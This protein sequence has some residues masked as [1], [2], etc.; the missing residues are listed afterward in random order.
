M[1]EITIA[2][3]IT[4]ASGA[5]AGA[6]V[7]AFIAGVGWRKLPFA[8]LLSLLSQAET[9][10]QPSDVGTAAYADTA[11]LVDATT[12]AAD[13]AAIDV[14]LTDVEEN[15]G[16]GEGGT[17]GA[18]GRTILL[19][20][21]TPSNLS[22]ADGDLAYN[23]TTTEMWTKVSGAWTG[24]TV[25]KGKNPEFSKSATHIRWRLAGDV[26][27]SDLVPLADLEG[28]DGADGAPGTA[29]SNGNTI[30]YGT[31]APSGG[32]GVDGDSYINK[33]TWM[34]YGP[35]ASGAWPTGEPMFVGVT[36]E[37]IVALID[38][39]FGGTDWPRGTGGAASTF[40]Y[41]FPITFS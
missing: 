38:D 27:W 6:Y 30:I 34:F 11:D 7:S 32:V 39:Y 19:V 36:G 41:T 3:S 29:G 13:I 5:T 26:A 17:P 31:V 25:L 8:D 4:I 1:A 16:G 21:G 18:D 28:A 40:P 14:R 24:P 22:G 2:P 10:L 20:S 35:K 9:A 37:Q 15:G 33:T 12:Y 23:S